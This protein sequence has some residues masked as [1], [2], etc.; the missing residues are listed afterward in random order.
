MSIG[1]INKIF[2][3]IWKADK[4]KVDPNLSKNQ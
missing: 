3:P 1:K 4:G 2:E